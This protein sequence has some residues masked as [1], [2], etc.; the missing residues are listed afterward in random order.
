MMEH[1]LR[2]C[3]GSTSLLGEQIGDMSLEAMA[4]G[5]RGKDGLGRGAAWAWEPAG[6]KGQGGPGKAKDR[7]LES[8]GNQP[9]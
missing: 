5:A 9:G 8:G 2:T 3:S 6:W 7:P 1:F 4:P